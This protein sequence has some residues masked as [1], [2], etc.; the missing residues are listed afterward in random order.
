M[1][2]LVKGTNCQ[3]T[4]LVAYKFTLVPIFH[5]FSQSPNFQGNALF[6]LIFSLSMAIAECIRYLLAMKQKFGRQ[7]SFHTE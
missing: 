2:D 7:P 1:S 3:L 5:I 4:K 6:N